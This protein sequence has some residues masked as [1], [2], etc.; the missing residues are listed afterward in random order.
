MND[1]MQ[2]WVDAVIHKSVDKAVSRRR[3]TLNLRKRLFERV[4]WQYPPWKNGPTVKDLQWTFRWIGRRADS[5]AAGKWWGTESCTGWAAQSRTSRGATWN[6]VPDQRTWPTAA[7]FPRGED[8]CC[9]SE[10][11]PQWKLKKY[12][13]TFW[14][15]K[16]NS[17]IW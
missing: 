12:G 3:Y 2:E 11:R 1:L 4:R 14:T 10:R 16:K 13:R 9:S 17:K 5:G 8:A 6:R 15:E 7:R